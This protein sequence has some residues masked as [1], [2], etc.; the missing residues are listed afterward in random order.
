MKGATKAELRH[1]IGFQVAEPPPGWHAD[2]WASR[3]SEARAGA[4]ILRTRAFAMQGLDVAFP[5]GMHPG[6]VQAIGQTPVVAGDRRYVAAW[7]DELELGCPAWP[8]R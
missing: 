3:M 4:R 7:P 1:G 5:N 8:K 2:P 6:L